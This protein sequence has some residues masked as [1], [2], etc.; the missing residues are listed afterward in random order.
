MFRDGT[1]TKLGQGAGAIGL[2]IGIVW[3]VLLLVGGVVTS[4]TSIVQPGPDGTVRTTKDVSHRGIDVIVGQAGHTDF[5]LFAWAMVF[6]GA[7]VVAAWAL[8]RQSVGILG[9]VA[10]ALVGFG[11]LGA[12]TVGIPVLLSGLFFCLAT[13]SLYARKQTEGKQT[14][15][16]TA[17]VGL[18]ALVGLFGGFVVLFLIAN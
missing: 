17:V 4:R 9:V 8:W 5:V 14:V 10:V 2:G 7:L 11:I 1:Q 16:G 15:L 3:V 6:L 12:M 13:G 18:I